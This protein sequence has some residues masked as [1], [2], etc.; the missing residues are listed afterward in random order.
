M[1]SRTERRSAKRYR[2]QAA[3][4]LSSRNLTLEFVALKNIEAGMPVMFVGCDEWSVVKCTATGHLIG[5]ATET[6]SRF[7]TIDVRVDGI[8]SIN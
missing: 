6:K 8:S 7:N 4:K 3:E 2:E 1:T 5:F